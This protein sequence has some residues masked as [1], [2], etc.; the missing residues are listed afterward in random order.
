MMYIR[1]ILVTI[2]ALSNIVL[3]DNNDSFFDMINAHYPSNYLYNIIKNNADRTLKDH[4][5]SFDE[6]KLSQEESIA[7]WDNAILDESKKPKEKLEFINTYFKKIDNISRGKHAFNDLLINALNLNNA[8]IAKHNDGIIDD[9]KYNNFLAMNLSLERVK[10][11]KYFNDIDA[12]KKL[13]KNTFLA[14]SPKLISLYNKFVKYSLL[15]FSFI[16]DFD[17]SHAVK[18]YSLT[19][20]RIQENQFIDTEYSHQRISKSISRE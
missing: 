3:A 17:L 15:A 12:S 9:L 2:L 14:F 13:L 10:R 8:V 5:I 6:F 1:Y 7:N 20:K 19:E 4:I 18:K 11:N 16:F